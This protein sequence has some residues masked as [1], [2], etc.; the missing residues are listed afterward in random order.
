LKTNL[1]I[2][3]IKNKFKLTYDRY[4][5]YPAAVKSGLLSSCQITAMKRHQWHDSHDR[6]A[7]TE[8]PER[9]PLTGK[10]TFT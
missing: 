7:V 2:R 8:E 3:K 1:K 5:S 10:P 6:K 4:P 9:K